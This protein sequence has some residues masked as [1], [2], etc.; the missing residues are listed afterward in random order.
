MWLVW[1]AEVSELARLHVGI[2]SVA[3]TVNLESSSQFF[4]L[5]FQAIIKLIFPCVS[6]YVLNDIIQ[7]V[8]ELEEQN[9]WLFP[10][11][12]LD[13]G[14]VLGSGAFGVVKKATAHSAKG[15]PI[16]V[17]VKMLKGKNYI[18]TLSQK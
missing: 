4:A 17:A 11:E 1:F 12:Q 10:H 2:Y 7:C 5:R 8:Y 6:V 13:I 3:E 16:V 9:Q 18:S 14:E 15:A